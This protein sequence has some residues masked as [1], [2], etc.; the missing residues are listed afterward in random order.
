LKDSQRSFRVRRIF[1]FF[2]SA[3]ILMGM[4]ALVSSGLRFFPPCSGNLQAATAPE[5]QSTTTEQIFGPKNEILLG[6]ESPFI[7]V[8]EKVSPAVVNIRAEKVLKGGS[9]DEL[10]PF[11][12]FFRRF[13]GEVPD[14]RPQTQR[15]QS[16]GSGFIFREDGYIITNNHVVSDAENVLVKL[17]DGTEHKAKII[18]LDRDTDIAVLK[19]DVEGQLPVAEFGNSDQLRVGEWVMAIG[20]P[21]PELGLDRTVTV[22][23]VS[24]K[25]RGNLYFGPDDTPQYQNYI[26][27]DASINPGNSGGPLVNVRGE[28]VG[29]NSAITNPT[30]VGFNIG[31]GFAIPVNLAKSVIPDLVEK[32]KVS[33][34]FLGITFQPVTRTIADAR[35]LPSEQGVL[36][37]TVQTGSPADKAG[38]ELGDIITEFDGWPI[39]DEQK[40]RMSVAQAGPGREVTVSILRDGK[41]LTKKLTLADRDKFITATGEEPA[42]EK[43]E[44]NWLGLELSST[45]RDL[46]NQYGLEFRTGV[47]V[48]GLEPGSPAE[49]GGFEVGDIITKVN[50]EEVKSLED[51]RSMVKPLT[52]KG[53][54]I[55]FLVYRNGE[56]LFVAVKP[57]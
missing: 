27:T 46:T 28:V 51:Y 22:G 35:N 41:K 36:V 5:N 1:I 49:L 30:G 19:I 20:N 33:R 24:A 29:I 53:K 4:G 48:M 18:G 45:T 31:I 9:Y 43:K 37:R 42:E 10:I 23:V 52:D 7:Q 50:D 44:E 3:L 38:I 54:A 21:F 15:G 34:G 25:G 12:D 32:G 2:V 56:P 11:E 8:A 47:M 57:E 26:Q 40:F 17:P 13:F 16:L 6:Q 55:L 39:T 14:R